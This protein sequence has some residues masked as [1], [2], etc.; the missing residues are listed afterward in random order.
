[1][2]AKNLV[3]ESIDE[4]I[5]RLLGL[6]DVF[7]LDYTTY[8]T[9]LKEKLVIVSRGKNTIPREEEVL[10][11]EEFK[12]VKTK[13]GRFKPKKKKVNTGGTISPSKFLQGSAGQKLLTGTKTQPLKI[14]PKKEEKED[15]TLQKLVSSIRKSVES[16]ATSLMQQNK[17]LDRSYSSDRKRAENERRSSREEG[18]ESKSGIGGALVSATKKILAPFESI[19]DRIFKFFFWILLG[20][21]FF[22]LMDW[23]GNP[24]NQKKISSLGR[25]VKDWWPA[26]LTGF[27]AFCTPLGGFVATITG[28]LLKGL[29]R[30]ALLNPKLTAIIGTGALA[31][32]A[33]STWGDRVKTQDKEFDQLKPG[34]SETPSPQ[35]SFLDY[36][37]SGGLGG[38]MFNAGGMVKN[39]P[40]PISARKI[41]YASGGGISNSSGIRITGAGPDTQLIAAQPGEVVINKAA[42][43]AV[44]A[45]RLLALNSA[46]GGPNANR[47]SYSNNI[48][49]ANTGG[50]IEAFRNGGRVGGGGSNFSLKPPSMKNMIGNVGNWFGGVFDKVKGA[51]SSSK[52]PS[53]RSAQ[54][55]ASKPS[56][57]LSDW[58]TPQGK[59]FLSTIRFAE[60]YKDTKN[61]YNVLYGGGTAPISKMTVKE[62]IDMYDTK[63][64]PKR[65]GGGS[66]NY[67]SGSG[68]VGAYQF[69][70]FT[71]EDLI[72][73]GEVK[74]DQIM[75]PELQD[76]LGWTLAKN[77]G[78]N[79][80]MLKSGG[81]SSSA[82]DMVAPEWASFPN[83]MGPDAKGRVGT[84]ASYYGQPSKDPKKLKEV[85]N[86]QLQMLLKPQ[87]R[88]FGGPISSKMISGKEKVTPK[89]ELSLSKMISGN[90]K[91]TQKN[92][93][94]LSKMISGDEQ[95]LLSKMIFNGGPINSKTGISMKGL[96]G[97]DTQLTMVAMKP[98][99]HH[100]VIPEKFV[101]SGGLNQ[102]R[103]SIADNDS[104]S[105]WAKMGYRNKD[106]G[107]L[108]VGSG[109]FINLPDQVIDM[110]AKSKM[111]GILGGSTAP[112]MSTSP[113]S[114]TMHRVN[115]ME[116]YYGIKG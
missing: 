85:Y 77:R 36:A 88:S 116:K 46:Y 3:T 64:L 28:T 101:S 22:K 14:K 1:M 31:A 19:F 5:L 106:I 81:L 47:P 94:P 55:T 45:D 74:P 34:Y 56:L 7:D 63:R 67:G 79:L 25:F 23:L 38:Q 78:I 107:P 84:N 20:R 87:R 41:S 73:R 29:L 115:I 110:S 80:S 26:I 18:L 111:S 97:G 17:L 53:G 43:N 48:R 4:R 54:A 83:L 11:R 12:R 66:V 68:A 39:L 35:K 50:L 70:P 33:G 104:T 98:G 51:F 44:G 58:Q 96:F 112:L 69:M 60:H 114:G 71:L 91:V 102:I 113:S 42:V 82:I 27:L 93:L 52:I 61:P 109:A 76:K 24:A 49:L 105:H 92:E 75:T 2:A 37:S 108:P 16:I 100:E 40:T 65:L 15:N 6:E 86:Q 21:A 90:E 99:E 13:Q 103:K 8:T 89:N 10:L 59:A 9:L 72:R 30:L 95:P 57:P 32:W 62:V